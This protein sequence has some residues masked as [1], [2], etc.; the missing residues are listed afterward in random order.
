MFVDNFTSIIRKDTDILICDLCFFPNS[1]QALTVSPTS[2]SIIETANIETPKFLSNYNLSENLQIEHGAFINAACL[3]LNQFV[4]LT[5]KGRLAQFSVDK[6]FTISLDSISVSQNSRY[7]CVTSYLSKYYFVGDDKGHLIIFS[8]TLTEIY[9]NHISK[10]IKNLQSDDESHHVFSVKSVSMNPS[11]GFI[12]LSNCSIL[13]FDLDLTL[14]GKAEFSIEFELLP[15]KEQQITPSMICSSSIYDVTAIYDPKGFI[16]LLNNESEVHFEKYGNLTGLMN[17]KFSVDHRILVLIFKKKISILNLVHRKIFESIKKEIRYSNSLCVNNSMILM[18]LNDQGIC[19]YPLI[20]LSNSNSPL[21]FSSNKIFELV[22]TDNQII[23]SEHTL[24]PLK[25]LPFGEILFASMN[26]AGK[27][28][29]IASENQLCLFSVISQKFIFMKADSSLFVRGIEW[30]SKFMCVLNFDVNKAIFSIIFFGPKR[31]TSELEALKK[32]DLPSRPLFMRSNN[33]DKLALLFTNQIMIIDKQFQVTA[34]PTNGLQLTEIYPHTHL[35]FALCKDKSGYFNLIS[36]SYDQHV[37]VLKE[38]V[39]QFF[40][41]QEFDLIFAISQNNIFVSSTSYLKFSNFICTNSFPIGV[42]N[43]KNISICAMVLISNNMSCLEPSLSYF[44]DYAISTNRIYHPHNVPKVLLSLDTNKKNK[45]SIILQSAVFLLRQHKGKECIEFLKN[46]PS[47]FD[48]LLITALRCVESNERHDV[49]EIIG[50]PSQYFCKLANVEMTKYESVTIRFVNKD[51]HKSSN[52]SVPAL[53]LPMMLE[54]EGCTVAFP[55]A[56]Y[57][58]SNIHRFSKSNKNS[59]GVTED[60]EY[61]QVE[62]DILRSFFRFIEPILCKAVA[63]DTEHVSCV[64]V[65]MDNNVYTELRLQFEDIIH[66]KLEKMMDF[67]RPLQ[68]ILFASMAR[69]PIHSFLV[70]KRAQYQSLNVDQIV[71]GM[72]STTFTKGN[73][74]MMLTN[75]DEEDVERKVV[76][77]FIYDFD[78][79]QKSAEIFKNAGLKKWEVSVWICVDRFDIANDMAKREG[80]VMKSLQDSEW[81]HIIVK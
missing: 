2:I 50:N 36:M 68:M 63:I 78:D 14:L 12:F 72:K 29:S 76:N 61:T 11:K 58:I 69:Y 13:S 45:R 1:K 42:F 17:M 46:F 48:E 53:L 22:P 38:N 20:K 41:S 81:K 74:E 54:D 16:C 62:I 75:D 49:Y 7:T 6:S 26:K 59:N 52:L 19:V 27:F 21:M 30:F 32:M 77:A 18:S 44:Y 57:L 5:N 71:K 40:L 55:A 80:E 25:K 31:N 70:E 24:R 65:K 66:D 47:L 35:I 15:L 10:S 51:D 56:F 28:I 9:I 64:G 3:S 34:I 67:Y 4:V 23:L 33:K 8:P 43:S 37:L 60:I 79:V 39:S 73:L